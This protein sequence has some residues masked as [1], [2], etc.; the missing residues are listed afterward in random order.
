MEVY[1]V[2]NEVKLYQP[3]PQSYDE[4]TPL[5]LETDVFGEKLSYELMGNP[6]EPSIEATCSNP[7]KSFHIRGSIW[8]PNKEPGDPNWGDFCR[9]FL[10]KAMETYSNKQS[11][12]REKNEEKKHA[13]LYRCKDCGCEFEI[14][15]HPLGNIVVICPKCKGYIGSVSD[16]GYGPIAPCDVYIGEEIIGKITEEK[17]GYRFDSEK[18]GI[19][20]LLDGKYADLE[21]YKDAA[22]LVKDHYKQNDSDE[23][24]S[25]GT[26]ERIDII[27]FDET[28]LACEM[29]DTDKLQAEIATAILQAYNGSYKPHL[30]QKSIDGYVK[31]TDNGYS[32]IS[33][34][35]DKE[36]ILTTDA[37]L[38]DFIEHVFLTMGGLKYLNIHEVA[39]SNA[40]KEMLKKKFDMDVALSISD[41]NEP[42]KGIAMT[43]LWIKNNDW[44]RQEELE[45]KGFLYFERDIWGIEL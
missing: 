27:T 1:Y 40:V 38:A 13:R 4:E 17:Q 19:G 10:K 29:T 5:V 18:L 9:D 43:C 42:Y 25:S 39:N 33:R 41:T 21:C 26:P 37:N 35:G 45:A 36:V 22:A 20:N 31:H 6:Y 34:E 2:D 23:R 12:N 30:I 28:I 3:E 24:M 32:F 8:F 11:N 44:S 14:S 7:A 16:Y 15:K